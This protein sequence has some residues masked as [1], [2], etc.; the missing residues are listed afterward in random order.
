MKNLGNDRKK[1]QKFS[2]L[3]RKVPLQLLPQ[4]WVQQ[5]FHD[6]VKKKKH[7]KYEHSTTT[8]I[9]G[10]VSYPQGLLKS[11]GNPEIRYHGCMHMS[12]FIQMYAWN[13]CIF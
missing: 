11:P 2:N 13:V 9:S 8:A 5:K 4:T 3:S 6:M 1:I 10:T 12:K 7:K